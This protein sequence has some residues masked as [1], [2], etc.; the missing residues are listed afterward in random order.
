MLIN[1]IGAE[2]TE[3]S[4]TDKVLDLVELVFQVGSDR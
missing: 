4:K 3:V 1:D 2:G